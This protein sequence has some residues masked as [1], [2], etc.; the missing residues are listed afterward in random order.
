MK[1]REMFSA[2]VQRLHMEA[3]LSSWGIVA[4]RN[5]ATAFTLSRN[6][7]R[8][9]I[10]ARIADLSSILPFSPKGT[11]WKSSV[12]DEEVGEDACMCMPPPAASLEVADPC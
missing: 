6:S 5:F 7:G 4:H 3:I 10:A 8:S 9:F 1:R 2:I 12:D 11:R